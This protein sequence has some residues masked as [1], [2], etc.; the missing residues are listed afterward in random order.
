VRVSFDTIQWPV[1]DGGC[2]L[3]S[4]RPGGKSQTFFT[5]FSAQTAPPQDRLES[6]FFSS[7]FATFRNTQFY[8]YLGQVSKEIFKGRASLKVIKK[9]RIRLVCF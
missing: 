9:K 7:R 3:C 6:N 1:G 5:F 2:F 8:F 4:Y